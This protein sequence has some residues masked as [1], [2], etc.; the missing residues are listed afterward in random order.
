MKVEQ[1]KQI[2][3]KAIEQLS[4][5]LE[6]GHS[7]TLRK[8]LAAMARFHRYSLHNIMLI[9]SQRPDASHVAGFQTWK[10]LGRFVKKGAKGILI[11]APVLQRKDAEASD[12][13]EGTERPVVHFR[14]VYVFDVTDTDGKSLPELANAEGDPSGHTE[15]LK[16][17]IASRGIQLEYSDAIYPAQ[18]Q[19]SPGKI[20]LLPGQSAA[21]EFATLAHETGHSLLHQNGRRTETTKRV[22]ETEAEAVAFVVCEAIGLTAS[23]SANYIQLYSGDKETLAGSLEHVQRASAEILAAIVPTD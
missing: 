22:R 20:A 8:Y 16:E 3:S 18:G 6:A 17:F 12:R 15:R 1:A 14:A 21:E 13:E 4:Q 9:A 11:L 23:N 2:A 10:Q 7:E 19:C 5:A